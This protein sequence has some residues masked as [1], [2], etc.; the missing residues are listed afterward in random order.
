[1]QVIYLQILTSQSCA[2]PSAQVCHSMINN[3]C[4][5][6]IRL[7]GTVVD[8]PQTICLDDC[9]N[10]KSPWLRVITPCP[11]QCWTAE[12]A[13]ALVRA[14]TAFLV[15]QRLRP[16]SIRKF[17]FRCFRQL[18]IQ[19]L[20]SCAITLGQTLTAVSVGR[21]LRPKSVGQF[22]YRCT[23]NRRNGD[24]FSS[25]P[26]PLEFAAAPCHCVCWSK[27][28]YQSILQA[29]GEQVPTAPAL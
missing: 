5:S 3:R 21:R 20:Q 23:E 15:G 25:L 22:L 17:R 10:W 11:K 19:L 6:V 8:D 26:V 9:P 14:L 27:M 28:Q 24:P 29:I 7:T 16:K 18:Y 2:C 12:S 13:G 4:V 1:M